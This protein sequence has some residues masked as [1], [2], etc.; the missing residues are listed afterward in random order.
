M[1]VD[2]IKPKLRPPGTKRWKANCD[3]L[4]STSAFKFNLRRYNKDWCK[5]RTRE[6]EEAA[7]AEAAAAAVTAEASGSG[8]RSGSARKKKKDAS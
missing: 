2:P 7:A 6:N 5:K 8:G 1:Q 4:L 3:V